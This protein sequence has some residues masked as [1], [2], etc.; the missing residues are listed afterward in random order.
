MPKNLVNAVLNSKPGREF[1]Q[2]QPTF[3]DKPLLKHHVALCESCRSVVPLQL[4]FFEIFDLVDVLG[5]FLFLKIG[6][7]NKSCT[8]ASVAVPV[9]RVGPGCTAH[10]AP[11]RYS[12]IRTHCRRCCGLVDGPWTLRPTPGLRRVHRVTAERTTCARH[13]NRQPAGARA[14]I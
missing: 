7:Q 11:S 3:P 14:S 12:G 1:C 9:T 5:S 13:C 6:S 10:M 4:L 8:V 2:L